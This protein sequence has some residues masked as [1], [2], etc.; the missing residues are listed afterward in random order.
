MDGE[1]AELHAKLDRLLEETAAIS[2]SLSRADGTIKG[3][4]HYSIIEEHAHQLGQRLSCLVQARATQQVVASQPRRHRCPHCGS[5][6]DVELSDR[7]MIS[8]DGD[9]KMPDLAGHCRKCRRDFF[10]S[11]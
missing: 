10:P 9:V 1:L 11:A 4:P 8:I 3:V 7:K 2:V 5:I 6:C